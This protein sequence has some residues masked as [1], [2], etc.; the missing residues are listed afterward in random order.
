MRENPFK[1][2][3]GCCVPLWL[4]RKQKDSVSAGKLNSGVKE[5]YSY[6][7]QNFSLQTEFIVLPTVYS[8]AYKLYS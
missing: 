5:I 7:P 1:T 2:C 6:I 8:I 3:T 4:R